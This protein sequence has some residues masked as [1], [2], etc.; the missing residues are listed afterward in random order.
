MLQSHSPRGAQGESQL[1]PPMIDSQ[2]ADGGRENLQPCDWHPGGGVSFVVRDHTRYQQDQPLWRGLRATVVIFRQLFWS[3]MSGAVIPLRFQF[4]GNLHLPYLRGGVSH[5]DFCLGFG[6]P[7]H[8]EVA[9]RGSLAPDG[10]PID[11]GYVD[12]GLRAKLSGSMV[13][14]G[15]SAAVLADVAMGSKALGA[16]VRLR[17]LVNRGIAS[18]A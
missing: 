2:E 13:S 12:V 10:R 3:A 1:P 5:P 9:I 17:R 6:A 15:T 14:K 16:L 8:Q 11:C 4:G 7:I 18:D